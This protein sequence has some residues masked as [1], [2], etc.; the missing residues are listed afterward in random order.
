MEAGFSRTGLLPGRLRSPSG[1]PPPPPGPPPLRCPSRP[2]PAS[3]RPLSQ[4]HNPYRLP[5]SILCRH[6][7]LQ[8]AGGAEL[9]TVE[10]ALRA[11]PYVA[12]PPSDLETLLTEEAFR[13]YAGSEPS[14]LESRPLAPLARPV[15]QPVGPMERAVVVLDMRRIDEDRAGHHSLRDGAKSRSAE[16]GFAG[17]AH[18]PTGHGS[19]LTVHVLQPRPIRSGSVSSAS[20]ARSAGSA[21]RGGRRRRRRSR[22]RRRRSL[23]PVSA[24]SESDTETQVG[25]RPRSLRPVTPAQDGE[26]SIAVPQ[27]LAAPAPAPKRGGKKGKKKRDKSKKKDK[28][29]KERDAAAKMEAFAALMGTLEPEP[30]SSVATTTRRPTG[31]KVFNRHLEAMMN[32]YADSEE[33]KD[34][35]LRLPRSFG[36]RSCRFQLPLNMY[37]LE[38]ISPLEYLTFHTILS[39]KREFVY[40][41]VFRRH[42][43]TGAGLLEEAVWTALGEVL[44]GTLQEQHVIRLTQLLH[45]PLNKLTYPQFAGVAAL[46][47]R[48]FLDDFCPSKDQI[49]DRELLEVVDFQRLAVLLDG[50]PNPRPDTVDLLWEI[51][52]G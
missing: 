42:R 8:R 45:D 13:R 22:R 44:G 28:K 20:S 36:N 26:V 6:P 15:P 37:E 33:P 30:S 16:R 34:F 23:S 7:T 40:T 47:E 9:L 38:E 21:S 17:S 49:C 24:P 3:P 29:E 46:C 32:K 39:Q 52:N 18:Q 41:A 12:A 51:R 14:V 50:V 48:L 10:M 35:W 11:P 27:L 5:C 4:L 31:K 2:A 43:K 19:L 1:A 25:Q